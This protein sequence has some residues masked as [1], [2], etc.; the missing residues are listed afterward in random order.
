MVKNIASKEKKHGGKKTKSSKK[1]KGGEESWGATGMPM[2]Y[3][4]PNAK[5]VGYP[6]NSGNNAKTAYGSQ[7]PLNAGIG[8]LAP[9]TVSKSLTANVATNMKTGGLKKSIQ[10]K[11]IKQS[12]KGLIPYI[13]SEPISKVQSKSTN[14]VSK[15]QDFL[16]DLQKDYVK[17]VQKASSVKIGNQRLIN[18]GKKQKTNKTNIT[19]NKKGGQGSDF[20]STLNSRGPSNAPNNYWGVD[21][22]KWFRQFNKTANYIPNTELAKAATPKLLEGPKNDSVIGYNSFSTDFAAVS[23]GKLT[24]KSAKPVKKDTKPVKKDTKSVKKDTKPVKKDTKSVKKDTKSVKKD[25]KSVKK[26]SKSVKKDTKS[27]KK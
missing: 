17:S 20:I 1:M 27:V 19:K 26:D 23:G 24:K 16:K 2:Q 5:L 12:G 15:M 21:G 7:E 3:Y 18:G 22:E 25:T 4:D 13:S 14:A 8:M 9:N 10:K 6:I 11:K